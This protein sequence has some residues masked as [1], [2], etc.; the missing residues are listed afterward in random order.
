LRAFQVALTQ[1]GDG[2]NYVWYRSTSRLSG[3]IRPVR[4]FADADGR[5]CRELRVTLHAGRYYSRS[6]DGT[7]CR[8]ADGQWSLGE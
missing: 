3:V 8:G 1:V 6:M 7:A 2:T 5:I 4:S